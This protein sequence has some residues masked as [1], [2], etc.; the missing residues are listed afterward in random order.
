MKE[1]LLQGRVVF[2]RIGGKIRPITLS[3]NKFTVNKTQGKL[4]AGAAVVAAYPSIRR[5]NT[6]DQKFSG[7]GSYVLAA[8]LVSAAYP[9][10]AYRAVRAA[11]SVMNRASKAF[12]AG[13]G[14]SSQAWKSSK[15]VGIPNC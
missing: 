10:G 9:K 12:N 8:A 13:F 15:K 4:L 7:T 5:K 11:G 6:P 14:A 2:R 3:S 1:A